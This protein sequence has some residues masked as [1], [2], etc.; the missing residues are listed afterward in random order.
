MTR[1]RLATG[2]YHDHKG[3][4]LRVHV[5]GAP[6][7]RRCDAEGVSYATHYAQKGLRW[8]RAERTRLHAGAALAAETT[9]EVGETFAADVER[10]LDTIHSPGHRTNTRGYMAHWTQPFGA[11]HRNSITDVEAQTAFARID[12]ADSTRTHVRKALINFYECLNGKSGYN[13]GRALPKPAKP[14]EPV[15]DLPWDDIE[16]MWAVMRPS[17]AKARLQLMAYVG[18]P[19]KQIKALRRSD[20]R[21]ATRELVVHPRR[22]GAGVSG[23]VQSLSAAAVAALQEFV[24][25]DAFGPFQN[26]QLVRAF[27]SA[28]KRARVTLPDGARPYDLRHSYLTEVARSGA[29]I[30]D[31]AR[32]G[33]HA[34]LEQAARY[35]K[36]VTDERARKVIT[37]VPRFG[38]TN[39]DAVV[40]R[41]G[42]TIATEKLPKRSHSFHSAGG[43]GDAAVAPDRGGKR[44]RPR[45]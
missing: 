30:R 34:T 11:R 6:V 40:P 31:I 29:D 44:A 2:I 45:G 15:R 25:L 23:Q 24:R 16:A 4:L 41:N 39:V 7:D 33:M 36:G 5:D 22:K 37:S 43:A 35:T 26:V 20:V 17:K 38:A 12:R 13:P 8:L 28:A 18:L 19:Q 42:A 14:E 3:I 9:A 21:L 1:T 27:H 32:L 10:F